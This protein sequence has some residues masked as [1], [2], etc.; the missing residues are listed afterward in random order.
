MDQQRRIDAHIAQLERDLTELKRQRNELSPISTLPPEILCQILFIATTCPYDMR[1]AFVNQ[2]RKLRNDRFVETLCHVSHAWRSTALGCQQLWAEIEVGKAT[3]P[4]QVDFMVEHAQSRPVSLL[5]DANYLPKAIEPVVRVLSGGGDLNRITLS[6]DFGILNSLLQVARP[7]TLRALQLDLSNSNLM[8]PAMGGVTIAKNPLFNREM[9]GLRELALHGVAI[10]LTSPILLR[11]PQLVSLTLSIPQDS[12]LSHVVHTLENMPLLQQLYIQFL[13]PLQLSPGTFSLIHLPY[14]A[15]GILHGDSASVI[16]TLS[17]LRLPR[18]NLRLSIVCEVDGNSNPRQQGANLFRALAG[19]RSPTKSH[20]IQIPS[21]QPFSPHALGLCH[22]STDSVGFTRLSIGSWSPFGG[23]CGGKPEEDPE[24]AGIFA[25]LQE[26]R[27]HNELD[28]KEWHPLLLSHHPKELPQLIGWSMDELR[29]FRLGDDM[30]YPASLWLFLSECPKITDL[31]LDIR[32]TPPLLALLCTDNRENGALRFPSLR[33]LD[34]GQR[35]PDGTSGVPPVDI[36]QYEG[37]LDLLLQSLLARQDIRTKN[38][39]EKKW[40]LDR[41]TTT[42][43]PSEVSTQNCVRA[44]Q[45]RWLF[46]E[47]DY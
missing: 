44:A 42:S 6:G 4:R 43:L 2:P 10:P 14:L 15:Q 40:V 45:D 38:G 1:S 12:S 17:Y 24:N 26:R 37:L 23:D 8:N 25:M 16:A 18:M 13:G 22:L 32:Q 46:T 39:V 3:D 27:S 47:V 9:P 35:I 20:A 7:R 36:G 29:V 28:P 21:H 11:S 30:M 19:S 41:I 5:I 31:V 34:V 33:R